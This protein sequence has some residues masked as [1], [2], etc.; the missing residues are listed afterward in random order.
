[1]DLQKPWRRSI[2]LNAVAP[3]FIATGLHKVILE[4]A[5]QENEYFDKAKLATPLQM[6]GRDGEIN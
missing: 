2:R 4:D 3:G 6:L 1:M 5:N